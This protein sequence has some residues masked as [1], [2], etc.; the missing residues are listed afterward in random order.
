MFVRIIF[1]LL[2]LFGAYCIY[3]GIRFGLMEK[4]MPRNYRR[5]TQYTGDAAVRQGWAYITI[6]SVSLLILLFGLIRLNI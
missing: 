4:T 6:G 1:I 5:S 2:S 3:F